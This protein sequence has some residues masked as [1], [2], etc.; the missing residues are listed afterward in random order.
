MAF[1]FSPRAGL[2]SSDDGASAAT[3]VGSSSIHPDPRRTPSRPGVERALR[4]APATLPAKKAR[5]VVRTP[6]LGRLPLK[7]QVNLLLAIIA[8]GLMLALGFAAYDSRSTRM[9]AAQGQVVGD[10]L[11]H[12]QR[13]AKAASIAVQG[14]TLA[15]E[16]LQDSLDNLNAAAELLT[17]GGSISGN[18]VAPL[19][20]SLQSPAQAFSE[21]WEH[22]A[23]IVGDV[24]EQ[25]KVLTRF[26][27]LAYQGRLVAAELIAVDALAADAV[28]RSGNSLQELILVTQMDLHL[29]TIAGEMSR[30]MQTSDVR[31]EDSASLVRNIE[32][33]QAAR[34]AALDGNASNGIAPLRTP[35]ARALIQD[36][37]P[38]ADAFV[39]AALEAQEALPA[40]DR[41][42]TAG[43]KVLFGSDRLTSKI[44]GIRSAMTAA[45]AERALSQW[46]V[47]AF[48]MLSLLGL[49]LLGKAYYD[50][51]AAKAREADEQLEDAERL[52]HE[53]MRLHDQTQAAIL[54]LMNELQ[55]VA[56]GNLTVQA[57]VSDDITGAIA[58]SVNFTIEALR[59]LVGRINRTAAAVAV[60][61]S[62]AQVTSAS[63]QASSDQ[64]S[65][66]I[67]E[68]GEA[69]LS[70][71]D[72]IKQVSASAAESAE[73]ARQSL[74]AADRGREA[75]QNAILG[76][77]GIRDQIQE[78][79]K[80][81]KRLGESS[82]EIGEIIELISNIT[83]QTNVL[84]LNAA[85]QAASAGEAGRGFTVVAEEVQRLAELSAEAT[86]QISGLVKA[87]Q[88]DTHDAVAA[89]ERSTQGVV[90][91]ARLSDDAGTALS[92]IGQVSQELADL[93]MR[94]SR[95]TQVQA[96]SAESVAQSIQRILLVTEQTGE[97]TQRTARSILELSELA[98]ELRNSVSRFKVE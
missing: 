27:Q 77:N 64:Q 45:S 48:G 39:K 60:A 30:L 20:E 92:S 63:L 89:M 51:S 26:S 88:S 10:A 9:M 79:S 82:Q 23:P 70:M 6:L 62:E 61:S 65:R 40:L 56:D 41:A 95:T 66:E 52:E 46:L 43:R 98:G 37:I 11:M 86:R 54:R 93:I 35:E 58:D 31:A 15:Y 17:K 76:M 80:R 96:R 74:T 1:K 22:M 68:T 12:S 5:T 53:T 83:E 91:G 49:L 16:Q 67:R 3:P 90:Q 8:V 28:R 24:I 4:S 13:L 33:F 14:S 84:A 19:S 78:T 42:R 7:L 18:E 2:R 75:V 94:I 81:I 47:I 34:V 72:Q 44:S 21:V 87:I 25:Q 32:G 57:T 59:D 97:G 29:R 38:K 36:A 50:D 71:A 55:E 85:I 69:V 73:V